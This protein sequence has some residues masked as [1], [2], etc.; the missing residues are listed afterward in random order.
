[1]LQLDSMTLKSLIVSLYASRVSKVGGISMYEVEF[2][3]SGELSAPIKLPLNWQTSGNQ[4][5]KGRKR[6]YG[7]C[8]VRL[9]GCQGKTRYN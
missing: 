9:R 5:V 8:V 2:E 7:V 4:K 6:L 3:L 1:M